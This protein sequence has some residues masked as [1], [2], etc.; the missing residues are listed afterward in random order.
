MK[1]IPLSDLHPH[2]RNPRLDPREDVVAQIAAQIAAHGFDEAHAI[3]VRPNA[4]GYEIISGHHRKLAAERAGLAAVP[5]H[6]RK[7]TDDEAYMALVLNNAQGELHPLEV[8]MHALGSGLTVRDYAATIG[9]MNEETLRLRVAAARVVQHVLDTWSGLELKSLTDEAGQA[10]WRCYAE[11][12]VAPDW[13]WAALVGAIGEKDTVE[14]TRKRVKLFA[15]VEPKPPKGKDR[16]EPEVWLDLDAITTAIL[17]NQPSPIKAMVEALDDVFRRLT[18]A[19]GDIFDAATKKIVQVSIGDDLIDGLASRMVIQCATFASLGELLEFINPTLKELAAVIET[20]R[21]TAAA[22][23]RAAEAANVRI[24]RLREACSVAEWKKLTKAERA[25][26]L[27]TDLLGDALA[28]G[29]RSFTPQDGDDIEWAQWSWNPITGCLHNC[30][31]CYAREI[32]NDERRA[33]IF[34]LKFEPA[35]RSIRLTAARTM[36]VPK[37]AAK[38]TRYRNVFIGSMSDIFGKWVP[39]EW[40]EAVIA[41]VRMAK[42]WNFLFLTKFPDRMALFEFPDNAWVG[43]SIDTQDRVSRAEKAFAEVKAKVRWL[44]VEPMLQPLTFNR[45]DVFHWIVV[46]GASASPFNNTPEW[47]PPVAW[48]MDLK[49]QAEAA[50]VPFYAKTNLLGSEARDGL[51]NLPSGMPITKERTELPKVLRY[52]GNQ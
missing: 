5:A 33:K 11:I 26:L 49:R 47:K 20:M 32:A 12:H 36:K 40:I 7:M 17:D 9:G 1:N 29:E 43:T 37:E 45:L 28:V 34:P 46:G 2:P 51:L 14:V 8:G 41:E 39:T 50:G 42:D 44:S 18:E 19:K 21:E 6:V 16:W 23:L 52:R 48:I 3:I 22:A 27:P 25:A 35:L 10:H 38:D 24:A 4:A 31:Y 30:P 15:H 13:A